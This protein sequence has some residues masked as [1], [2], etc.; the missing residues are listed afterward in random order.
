MAGPPGSPAFVTEKEKELQV[1]TEGCI[2]SPAQGEEAREAQGQGGPPQLPQ[3]SPD[4][5]RG[6][7]QGENGEVNTCMLMCTIHS[8]KL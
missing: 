3:G 7:S 1:L 4:G 2:S 8:Y 5:Q 6:P